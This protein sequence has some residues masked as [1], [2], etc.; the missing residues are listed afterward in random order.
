MKI[1]YLLAT[2]ICLFL[3]SVSVFA[4]RLTYDTSFTP[5]IN[6]SVN[7]IEI[8]GDGKILIAGDFTVVNGVARNKIGRLNPDGS[9][10]TSFDANWLSGQFNDFVSIVAMKVLPD[11]KILIGGALPANGSSGVTRV[12]R[13]NADG[14]ADGSLTSLPYLDSSGT[15]YQTINKVDQLANGKILVCGKFLLPNGNQKPSLARYN[16]DGTYDS[17]FTTAINNDCNDLEVL[18]DGKYFVAGYYTTVNGSS[19]NGLTRFNP[20]DTVDTTFNT[21]LTNYGKIALESDGKL[22]VFHSTSFSQL[23]SRLNADGSTLVTYPTSLY[24]GNDV[25]FQ[26]NGKVII[27]GEYSGTIYGQSSDFN[28]FNTDGTHD[29]SSNRISF[30]GSSSPYNPKAVAVAADGKVIAGGPFT[31]F[32]S[33]S[34][35]QVSR[36]YLVRFVPEAIPI[37]P[38]FDFDGDG[39]DDIAVY[40]PSDTYWYLN[41]STAGFFAAQFGLSTDKPI[42]A[43]YDGDGKADIA[44]FRDGVW[45]WLRSSDSAFTTRVCGQAG[46]IPTPIYGSN[47]KAGFLVFRPSDG[48]FYV[49]SPFQNASLADMRNLHPLPTDKPVVADYDGDGFGD[50]AVFRDGQWRILTSNNL[51][52][53]QYQFGLA[54]DIPVPADYDGD[55]RTDYAVFRPSDGVWYIQKSTEGFYAVGWGLASDLPVPADYDGD[56]KTDIAVYRN[57]VWYQLLSTNSYHFE[58]FGLSN[59]I[60]AQLR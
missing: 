17:T 58:Q 18:P 49:Q 54:G 15:L 29:P 13:L 20:D 9:L 34:G 48:N 53:R 51:A 57:G 27:V 6:G 4:Q 11:G 33:N 16:F 1:K 38:K 55:G 22:V 60:P 59:D 24:R 44:I 12:R 40:R 8:L 25:A 5:A 45:M 43:D 7:F 42:A 21:A 28:R 32:F 50:L 31:S 52:L 19:H 56:G 35:G 30:S 3:L 36:P 2:L 26:P 46:D 37:K 41:R 39:K 10:D 23:V 47:G 14:T